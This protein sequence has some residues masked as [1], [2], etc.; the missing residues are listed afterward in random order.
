MSAKETKTFKDF[1]AVNVTIGLLWD[2][3]EKE[4]NRVSLGLSFNTPY[5]AS[6][7]RDRKLTIVGVDQDDR[8]QTSL[9]IDFPASATIGLAVQL[10]RSVTV[11][12]D[13]T[14]TDWSEWILKEEGVARMR[15]LGFNV[16]GDERVDDTVSARAGLE[17]LIFRDKIIFPVRAGLF[18]DPRPSLRN[19]TDVM[20]LSLG[21]GVTTDRYSLDCAYQLDY[22]PN[23]DLED[24]GIS[25]GEANIM[26]HKFFT[27]IIIRF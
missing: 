26:D 15:P 16:S 3:W 27:S 6:L 13:V 2:I 7:V 14:W 19:P 12:F 18:Y 20:G 21:F 4:N 24:I 8:S 5:T 11:A 25:G 10:S 22:A 9:D 17:Y 1:E 23:V